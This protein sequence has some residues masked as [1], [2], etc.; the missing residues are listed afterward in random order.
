MNFEEYLEKISN[1]PCVIKKHEPH[2]TDLLIFYKGIQIE[3]ISFHLR[4]RLLDFTGMFALFLIRK[5]AIDRND[6]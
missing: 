2:S 6:K 1:I 3:T 5:A 4:K